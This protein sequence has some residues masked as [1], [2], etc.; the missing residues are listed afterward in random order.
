MNSIYTQFNTQT[1]GLYSDVRFKAAKLDF[2][3]NTLTVTVICPSNRLAVFRGDEGFIASVLQKIIGAPLGICVVVENGDFEP[4]ALTMEIDDALYHAEYIPTGSVTYTLDAHDDRCIVYFTLPESIYMFAKDYVFKA[5][6][7]RLSNVFLIP[8]VFVFSKTE[9]VFEQMAEVYDDRVKVGSVRPY[10]GNAITAPIQSIATAAAGKGSAFCGT[11]RNFKML[12]SKGSETKPPRDYAVFTLVDEEANT[13]NCI[14]FPDKKALKRYSVEKL[15]NQTVVI[16]G[17]VDSERSGGVKII[18][19]KISF[20]TLQEA[21]L[22]EAAKPQRNY[23]YATPTPFI[24]EKQVDFFTTEQELPDNLKGEFVVFDVE[25]T[26][27]NPKKCEIIELGAVKI[28]DGKITDSFESFIH[29]MKSISEEITELTGISNDMV[30]DAPT[31]GDVLGD[32]YKFCYNTPLVAHNAKF[33]MG[34]I[35]EAGKKYRMFFDFGVFDTYEMARK[36]IRCSN[37]TLKAVAQHFNI[38]N[39]RAHRAYYDAATTA[40]VFIELQKIAEQTGVHF[41]PIYLLR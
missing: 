13:L 4:L 1:N 32:F 16:S 26:G 31:I 40:K 5:L 19:N 34:F 29:P 3:T 17:T 7:E 28:V 21:E 18:V 37:Y 10:I 22:P 35:R 27:L 2:T 20:C 8:I 30:K 24:D 15:N 23:I 41:E 38:V 12:K 25:T 33:D 11:I 9:D 39:K 36:L 14:A 6:L